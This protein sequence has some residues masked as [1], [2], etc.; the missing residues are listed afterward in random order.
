VRLMLTLTP[1]VCVC[2]G[3]VISELLETYL[4]MRKPN[5]AGGEDIPTVVN[6]TMS[7]SNKRS[8]PIQTTGI[9]SSCFY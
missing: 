1:V 6:E 3:I 5:W 4:D 9:T 2:A 8:K 7:S